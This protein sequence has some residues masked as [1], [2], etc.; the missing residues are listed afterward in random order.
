MVMLWD[1]SMQRNS[2][3]GVLKETY[4]YSAQ[5]IKICPKAIFKL[6]IWPPKN[7]AHNEALMFHLCLPFITTNIEHRE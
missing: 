4:F 2:T 3:Q 5:N 6:L 7:E 1:P